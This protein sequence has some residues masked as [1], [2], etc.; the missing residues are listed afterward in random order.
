MGQVQATQSVQRIR[1]LIGKCDCFPQAPHLAQ[2][3]VPGQ[4]F[5]G[6]IFG[7][8]NKVYGR[9]RRPKDGGGKRGAEGV[10]SAAS[11]LMG[12]RARDGGDRQNPGK[13]H[14]NP[15]KTPE[16]ECETGRNLYP[17]GRHR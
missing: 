1:I 6:Q 2:A 5:P 15:M 17:K 11:L 9:G 10:G 7:S 3:M 12:T 14:E 4:I 8:R 16:N 13:P